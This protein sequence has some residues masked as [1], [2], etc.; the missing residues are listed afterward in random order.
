MKWSAKYRNLPVDIIVSLP[1]R[2]IGDSQGQETLL[3]PSAEKT[4]RNY[5][6]EFSNHHASLPTLSSKGLSRRKMKW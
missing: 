1:H 3:G 6:I 4:T 2:R 5:D